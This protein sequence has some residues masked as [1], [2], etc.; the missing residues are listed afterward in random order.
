MDDEVFDY[1]KDLFSNPKRRHTEPPSSSPSM[2]R[3]SLSSYT[4][5]PR[6][7]SSYSVTHSASS[8]SRI[9]SGSRTVRCPPPLDEGYASQT[10]R[11]DYAATNITGYRRTLDVPGLPQSDYF[12]SGE[13]QWDRRPE[14]IGQGPPSFSRS[15]SAYTGGQELVRYTGGDSRNQIED[16]LDSDCETLHPADSISNVSTQVSGRRRMGTSRRPAEYAEQRSSSYQR[17]R[18]YATSGTCRRT[19]SYGESVG[20]SVFGEMP[21]YGSVVGYQTEERRPVGY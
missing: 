15:R 14:Y 11:S 12:S 9:T 7:T 10:G 3:D 19:Y 17:R 21:R 20:G 2:A 5:Q 6:R 16:D 18:E 4:S 1:Y 8:R 13:S